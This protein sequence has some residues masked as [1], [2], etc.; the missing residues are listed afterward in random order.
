MD[1]F[2]LFICELSHPEVALS[3]RPTLFEINLESY[4]TESE[5]A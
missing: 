1:G 5:R 2:T 3:P 4:E